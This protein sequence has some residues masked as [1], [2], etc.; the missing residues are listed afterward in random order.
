MHALTGNEG[1]PS[2]CIYL[3]VKSKSRGPAN[4]QIHGFK[5]M[6]NV[7]YMFVDHKGQ[8]YKGWNK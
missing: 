1:Q 8:R 2:Q 7:S 6:K 3:S 5:S 4:D